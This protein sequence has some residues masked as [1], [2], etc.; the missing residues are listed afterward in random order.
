M[1]KQQALQIL[2]THAVKNISGTGGG[3][4]P[5][6]TKKERY[7]VAQAVSKIWPEIHGRSMTELDLFNLS[8]HIKLDKDFTDD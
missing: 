8:L 5:E 2:I 7:S 1:D 3:M 6:I 4:R